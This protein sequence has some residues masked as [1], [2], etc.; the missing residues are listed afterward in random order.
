MYPLGYPGTGKVYTL[1]YLGTQKAYSL[2]YPSTSKVFALKHPATEK[3]YPL[4]Y[5]GTKKVF[6]LGCPGILKLYTLGY[7]CPEKVYTLGYPATK[8]CIL[9]VPGYQS[10]VSGY[11]SGVSG[12][13]KNVYSGVPGYQNV[14]TLGCPGTERCILWGTEIP[15]PV[16][17]GIPG[18]IP[19]MKYLEYVP[20]KTQKSYSHYEYVYSFLAFDEVTAPYVEPAHS[21]FFFLLSHQL[22]SAFSDYENHQQD[23]EQRPRHLQCGEGMVRG[24]RRGER[25]QRQR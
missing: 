24:G 16:V 9:R 7:P 20:Y 10:G 3:V 18:Y 13:P 22:G 15:N 2:G 1:G 5:P 25:W 4:G 12:Y 6:A 11:R 21:F 14:Y 8:R 17:Q 19:G 23:Q